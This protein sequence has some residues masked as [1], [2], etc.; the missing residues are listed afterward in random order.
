MARERPRDATTEQIINSHIIEPLGSRQLST[1]TR[2][3]L[4]AHLDVVAAKGL[5]Y[6]VVAHVRW[7]LVAIFD[8]AQGDGLTV[9]NPTSGLVTPKCKVAPDKRVIGV[10]EIR[11]AFMVLPI[12][13]RLVFRLPVCEGM[14]PGEITALQI[15]DIQ[16]DGIHITRRIYRGKSTLRNRGNGDR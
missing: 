13:E 15:G 16:A 14:R 11:R 2:K 6:S 1:I 12:R 5:S 8:M 4:Q 3:E 7:Q 9:H 10:A